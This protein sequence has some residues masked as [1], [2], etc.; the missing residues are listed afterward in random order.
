MLSDSLCSISWRA[1]PRSFV[2]L[3]T[4]YESNFI[5][6]GWLA[7]DLRR[8][9]GSLTSEVAG[10]PALELSVVEQCRYTTALQMTYVFYEGGAATRE[11][12]LEIRVYHDARLAEAF[13]SPAA[14]SHPR[15]RSLAAGVAPNHGKRWS[16]NML[17]N[18]W[19]EYCV[20]SGHRFAAPA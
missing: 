16:C 18:K 8:L 1:R 20:G 17:L 2:S 4:L 7:P 6:L 19:L 13:A 15:L 12:G 9:S 5:R 3:M 14:P 11:P 10:E